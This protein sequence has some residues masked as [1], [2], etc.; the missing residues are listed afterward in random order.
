MRFQQEEGNSTSEQ[1]V[2]E[3]VYLP[4]LDDNVIVYIEYHTDQGREAS[5][6]EGQVVGVPGGSDNPRIQGKE[7]APAAWVVSFGEFEVVK[8]S[9]KTTVTDHAAVEFVPERYK[10]TRLYKGKKQCK[11]SWCYSADGPPS[12]WCRRGDQQ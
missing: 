11:Y 3:Q 9:K 6:C 10:S 12:S 4:E 8:R 5:W 2:A 7:A 1:E